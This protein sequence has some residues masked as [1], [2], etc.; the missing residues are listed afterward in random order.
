MVGK[1][2]GKRDDVKALWQMAADVL[3]SQFKETGGGGGED[4]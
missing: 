2:G 1:G 4:V 3:D